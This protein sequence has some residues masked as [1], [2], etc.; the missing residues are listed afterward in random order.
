MK[1]LIVMGLLVGVG[2][3]CLTLTGRAEVYIG[4]RSAGSVAMERIDHSDW[5]R[6]LQTYV[7][8][9]GLVDYRAWHSSAADREALESY[10]LQLSAGQSSAGTPQA[11]RLAFWINAY[12]A[13]T[14]HGILREYPTSSIRN[15]TPRVV[16]YNIWKHLQLY[17]DGTPWSLNDIEHQILR[18][19]EVPQIHFAI[20]CASVGCPRLLNEA[21]T[22]EEVHQQLD[23][24]TLDFFRRSQNFR[25]SDGQFQLSAILDWFGRDFGASQTEQLQAISEWLP[26][27]EA[28]EAAAAGRGEVR[29]LKYDWNLNEQRE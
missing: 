26:T 24:N 23:R 28:R 27:P 25:Y 1:R 29:Y 13:V 7:N 18:K 5:T 10:L 21:Y 16:G 2:I 8:D 22:T 3:V 17:V 11:A 19:M 12:N 6:L 15:H 9:D 4:R 14:V 20:V